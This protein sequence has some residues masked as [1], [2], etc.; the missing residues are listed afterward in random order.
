[1]FSLNK[2]KKNEDSFETS[3]LTHEEFIKYIFEGIEN[4]KNIKMPSRWSSNQAEWTQWLNDFE[5]LKKR[6]FKKE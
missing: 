6:A 2:K 1:M 3:K 4:D 5:E